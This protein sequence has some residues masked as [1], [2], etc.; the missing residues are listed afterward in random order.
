M[1]CLF[2]CFLVSVFF[3]QSAADAAGAFAAGDFAAA[4]QAGES[5]G[6][7]EGYSLACEA[8]LVLGSYFEAGEARIRT[9]HRAINDCA[10]AIRSGDAGA[11]AYV[12]YAIGVGFEAKRLHSVGAALNT[13][14]LFTEAVMRFPDTGFAQAALAGWHSNVTREAGIGRVALG[15]SREEARRRFAIA[16]S[17]DPGNP[18][19]RFE[20]LRFLA[21]GGR[22]DRRAAVETAAVMAAMKPQGAFEAF[23]LE[24]ARALSASLAANERD[25]DAAITAT[26]PFEGVRGEAP[27]LKFKAPFEAHF[28]A[29]PAQGE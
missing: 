19:I 28:P 2:C 20:Q 29:R 24:R 18:V 3:A 10:Q 14:K 13:R 26:E 15:A 12:N 25:V 1:K 6:T 4:R 11:G 23:V 17:L 22:E 27:Q 5:A 9:L 16:I 8:G 7:A 21:A